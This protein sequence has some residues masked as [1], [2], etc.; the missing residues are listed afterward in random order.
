MAVW[1]VTA[2]RRFPSA[3]PDALAWTNWTGRAIGI[4]ALTAVTAAVAAITLV[5]SL[6]RVIACLE[7]EDRTGRRAG[8]RSWWLLDKPFNRPDA[9]LRADFRAFVFSHAQRY[10][11]PVLMVSHDE[12]DAKAA[13]GFVLRLNAKPSW[14]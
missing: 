2:Q 8:P 5:V 14:P 12:V 6:L 7:A 13:G 9:Q 3:W 4:G 1:S 11:L 10:Q